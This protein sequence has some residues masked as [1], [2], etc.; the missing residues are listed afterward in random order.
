MVF[1]PLMLIAAAAVP[2]LFFRGPES[3]PWRAK[4]EVLPDPM[5]TEEFEKLILADDFTFAFG[6]GSGLQ[7]YDII[8]VQADGQCVY[9][10]NA[11]YHLPGQEGW[12][13]HR[14]QAAPASIEVLRQALRDTQ[15]NRWHAAYYDTN[16]EDGTQAF[17]FASGGSR[18]KTVSCS[19][20]FPVHMDT[21][22]Q[23]LDEQFL[24]TQRPKLPSAPAAD[25]AAVQAEMKLC[26]QWTPPA[27]RGGG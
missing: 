20:H 12:R 9:T 15:F 1:L 4:R 21:V 23:V 24:N 22:S 19:N 7:G 25:E 3:D 26:G 13:Q 5:P 11:R 6:Y 2:F 16:V 14:C 27:T 18:V 8:R 17:F 10:F